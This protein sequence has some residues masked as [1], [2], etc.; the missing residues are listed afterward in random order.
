M[1]GEIAKQFQEHI[2]VAEHTLALKKS[3]A[4]AAELLLACFRN[5]GKLLLFGNGGSA[6]QA[7]H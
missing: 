7:Q 6:S 1:E 3:I 2:A 5:H 4:E